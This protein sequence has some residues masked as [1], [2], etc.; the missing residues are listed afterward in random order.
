MIR[1][2]FVSLLHILP[3]LLAGLFLGS[4]A[5]AATLTAQQISVGGY[6]VCAIVSGDA[7]CWGSDSNGQLGI[8]Y[9]NQ[10]ATLPTPVLGLG[11]GVTAIAAGSLHTCALVNGG[12]QCWG[13]NADGELGNGTTTDSPVPVPVQGLSSGVVSLSA[14][15]YHTCAVLSG[16][17]L[18]CWGWN[19]YG[20]LGDGTATDNPVPVPV[21]VSGIASG[22]TLVSGG[23]Y[24]TCTIVSGSVQCW[25]RNPDG[26]LGNGSTAD[27]HV[28]VPVNGLNAGVTTISA[29]LYH[30]CAIAS[31]G[32][33]C[34]GWNGNGQ[35]G[36]NTTVA[37][38]T[39]LPATVSGLGPGSGATALGAGGSHTCAI[40]GGAMK[41]WGGNGFGQLGNGTLTDDHVPVAVSGLAS[42]VTAVSSG[43]AHSCALAGGQ[44]RCW[45][46]NVD[47][48]M[49]LGD[50]IFVL[51][52]AAVVGM[53]SGVTAL[54]QG[55]SAYGKTCALNGTS[56]KCW[57]NNSWSFL[58]PA[59]AAIPAS[60]TPVAMGNLGATSMLSISSF[61][62]CY[63]SSGAVKCW[64]NN[65][66]GQLG[67]GT[68]NSN[69]NP[70]TAIASGATAV[71]VG[72]AFSC[73]LVGGG[74][75][76]WGANVQGQLGDGTVVERHSPVAVTNLGGTAIA[77]SLGSVHGCALIAGGSVKCWGYNADGELGN[78][79]A[80]N[81]PNPTPVSV[82]GLSGATALSAG[83]YHSCV[84]AGG[85]LQ[86]WGWNG[87]GQIGN[88]STNAALAP[89]AVTGMGS[90]VGVVSA[91]VYHTCA[92][93]GG[94]AYCWG[95][96]YGGQLGSGNQFDQLTPT[97]VL[98][99]G[100]GVTALAAGTS[101]T[102]AIVGGAT[103]CW[104]TDYFGEIGDGRATYVTTPSSVALGD[105]V[106]RNGFEVY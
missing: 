24:H 105:I 43:I 19:G 42:G 87:F 81:N 6:H 10:D 102:C 83:G 17:A 2:S 69:A 44:V 103:R 45:G 1:T 21:T 26:E 36:N 101:R 37:T 89:T 34:W 29:G 11:N 62:A 86:C 106:F 3:L 73:A 92:T 61:H 64:G 52:P 63:L 49:G 99:L 28:P 7:Q 97:A 18:K 5:S 23:G 35:L 15:Q 33:Q 14:G 100:S 20:Q 56:A 88:N 53:A 95:S 75:Q 55:S 104:G 71:S 72:Y 46:N 78:N 8:G 22:A 70:V 9:P 66:N 74:V 47:G 30:T 67:D 40:A 12:V 65:A 59:N 90:G 25:G 93:K 60:S 91:G 80:N 94:A 38:G 27:S 79:T 31:G 51:A 68:T 98:G 85:A 32:V 82:Q 50:G 16:G 13:Y 58:G 96:G 84:I 57:G 39:G 76:C 77:I 41:C 4:G 48:E 54:A